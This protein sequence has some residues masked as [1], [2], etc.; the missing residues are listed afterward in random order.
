M[1]GAG[2]RYSTGADTRILLRRS[3]FRNLYYLPEN[4]IR[5][6]TVELRIA[7][8]KILEERARSQRFEELYRHLQ[9]G[10]MPLLI[11]RLRAEGA[12]SDFTVKNLTIVFM[13]VVGFHH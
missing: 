13:D 6:L 2:L 7:Q 5:R 10:V 1:H 4:E 3:E 11:E 8:Q 9:D 12:I